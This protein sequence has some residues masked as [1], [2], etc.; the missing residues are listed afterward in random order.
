[1]VNLNRN[2]EAMSN[3]TSVLEFTE[4]QCLTAAGALGAVLLAVFERN[5]PPHK[6]VARKIKAVEAAILDLF[7]GTGAE[8]DDEVAELMIE[9]WDRVM[10]EVA[11]G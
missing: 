5:I 10:K 2:G 4:A 9:T 3:N 6:K 7:Q 1:M 11:N 8:I